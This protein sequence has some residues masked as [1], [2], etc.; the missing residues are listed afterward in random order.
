LKKYFVKGLKILV[1]TI[2]SVI[3]LFL[4]VLL[5]IQVP[6]V[7]D[8][9]KNKAVSYLEEKIHTKV[10]IGHIEIGL[11]KNI[12]V[13]KLYLESQQKDTLLYGEKIDVNISLFKLLDSQVKINSV[14]LSG[15][16]A[17]VARNKDSVY[18]FD[19]IIKAFA[20]KQKDTTSKPMKITLDKINLDKI[21]VRFDDE[22]TKNDLKAK[23]N[24]FDTRIKKFDLDQM[25]FE[26][27]KIKL[28]GLDL[29]FAQGKL[30][31]EVAVATK[32]IADSLAQHTNIK[33][34]LGDVALSRIKVG[35][36][37]AGTSL[38]TGI[39]LEK[40]LIRFNK[41]DIRNQLLELES[42]DINTLK[43][44]LTVG[45][46]EKTMAK[47]IAA[48]AAESEKSAS[49]WKFRLNQANLKNIAFRYD[50]QNAPPAAKGIDYKHLN[51]KDFN[52]DGEKFNFTPEVTSGNVYAF[53]VEEKSG[54]HIQSLKTEFYYG[55]KTAFLKKLYLK[56]PQTV[57]RDELIIS[58]PSLESL[59][60]NIA[61]LNVNASIKGSQ[62]G[63]KDILIFAP[64]L[65]KTNPFKSNPDAVMKIN[66]RI[67]GKV[68]N[69]TIP[70]LELSGIGT[71]RIAASGRIIGL[72]DAKNAY[73]DFNIRN[74]ESSSK[75]INRFVPANTI[76]NSIQLPS[77]LAVRG[78]FKGKVSNFN[79]NLNVSSSYGRAHVK[80]NFDQTRKNHEKYAANAELNN[81]DIGKLIKNKDVGKVTLNAKANGTGLNPK[82]ANAR[83][84]AKIIRAGYMGYNYA[85]AN[86]NGSIKNGEFTTTVAMKD[87]N[88]AFDLEAN[89]DFKDKYPKGKVKLNADIADLEKLNLHAGPLKLK[90]QLDAD[91]AT[92]DPDYLNGTINLHHIRVANETQDFG[93]DTI[94]IVAVAT[95][96]K[97]SIAVKSQLVDANIDGKYKLTQLGNAI[98]N[99]IAKYYN[100]NPTAK[101]IKTDPQ[102]VAFNVVVKNSP[103]TYNFLPELKNFETI[104]VEGR[105]NTVNDTIVLN[106][107][108]PKLIYGTNNISNAIVKIDT[109][110]NALTYNIFVD[111]I[112]NTQMELPYTSLIGSVQ[113]NTIDYI[114]LLKDLK[115]KD[116]YQIAGI[117]KSNNGNFELTLKDN[118]LL[119]YETWTISPDNAL[120]FGKDGINAQRFVLQK[121]NSSIT[122]HSQSEAP[123]APL[124]A[125]FKDF[126]I[127]TIT[128]ILQKNTLVMSG[129]ING[130][131]LFRNLDKP[132]PVF[133]ADMQVSDFTFNQS[134]VGNLA[135]KVD[136]ET[137]GTYRADIALTGQDNDVKLKGTYGSDSSMNMNLDIAKLNLKSVEGF[138]MGNILESSGYFTGNFK[139]GGTMKAPQPA[140]ELQFHDIAFR[141]K[142]TGSYYKSM[143]DKLTV[144]QNGIAFDNFTIKDEDNNEL[145][146]NGNLA[147]TNYSDYGFDLT[148]NADNF[149]AVNSKERDNDL[150]YGQLYLNSRLT[151]NG[152]F[153]KPVIGGRIKINK[154]T[155]F[156]VVLP[157]SDPSIVEREG[158]VEFID[159]DN[160]EFSKTVKVNDTIS[161][162]RFRG[163]NALVNI[164]IDKEA[165]LS[166][167]IDKGNGDYLK[168][169]GEARLTGGMNE[170]GNT[171]LTGRYEFT[172]GT[173]EMTFN[174]LKRKFEIKE[175]SYIVWTGSPTTAD[176]NVTAVY[177]TEAPPIDLVGDQLGDVTPAVRNTYKQRI[178]FETNL[179]M[180]GALLKP[181]ISFDIVLPEGN[182]M[183]STEII[184]NTQTK[185]AQIRQQPSE[186][187]KQVFALLL[188]NRFVGENP[189]AS[190]S[191]GATAETLARQS[192]SKILSQQLNNLAGDLIQGVELDFDLESTEDYTS[193]ARQ[194]RTDLNVGVSKRLLDDRLKVTVG[195]SFGLEGQQQANQQ[196][197]N[198]A[199]DL[200][201]EYQLSKDGRYRLRAYRKNQYQVA[202]QGQVVE[203]GVAFTITMS[204]N[205][206]REL[207]HRTRAE[208]NKGK[209]SDLRKKKSEDKL[210]KKS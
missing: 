210:D 85:N 69:I 182:N 73:F 37:N 83:V 22:I 90:G 110:D 144:S 74:L 24:H 177:K 4:L 106:A 92:A 178:P 91:I 130:N 93:I 46:Y 127:E 147:T 11:P 9:I 98:T 123:N 151:V 205:K 120:R 21:K 67:Y 159:Q 160:P 68:G 76:P 173:Y 75:D 45:K 201:A 170:S 199:G 171:T 14:A 10:T 162:S 1:W 89:G 63:F 20:S 193:G 119:N 104:N 97:N 109:K 2:A 187:N 48:A 202:L 27:P 71:T 99:S 175:G 190:E 166:L 128:S 43:G 169:R 156:T 54:L 132:T 183:V 81:F 149:R 168:L 125:D 164:E 140:G 189:F 131:A 194:N 172:E 72:P 41:I 198:F 18:N 154:D 32:E 124:S 33:L 58:Y 79:T 153:S 34:K 152:D 134:P 208:K 82:T 158:I 100:T 80:A 209:K 29:K 31:E 25:D 52:L 23:L 161:K 55:T 57:L 143:N 19:Y 49:P 121:E 196:Q 70:N 108:I 122:L 50:D 206:F 192:A 112:S 78:T 181:E 167:I 88:L 77:Q 103:V 12:I 107:S 86:L 36:D 64:Q 87:P 96:E 179:I 115:N 118:P 188:L 42:L 105:Y 197:N 111:D 114:L 60:N 17:N 142:E 53:T 65:A 95:P 59:R 204:Y 145:V 186:L 138:T 39:S 44:A 191:G 148:I 165:E 51:I 84:K 180:K 38:N 61:G 174:L 113:N 13:E 200:S 8:K 157:Q 141:S 40:S 116:R 129:N 207:F 56:T 26:V 62:V 101:R 117:L 66:S 195:S 136:N 102:Q 133:V 155:K 185:L 7:Q 15:I 47:N 5:L 176:V 28:D 30:V 137:A 126:K 150:Y 163:I 135:I 203:T 35:Y 6:F 94:A 3:A 16:T 184:N 146:I 139:I